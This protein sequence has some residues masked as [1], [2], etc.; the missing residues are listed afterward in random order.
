MV[1][2]R[3]VNLDEIP[4]R[5]GLGQE[6]LREATKL[7]IVHGQTTFADETTPS[8][9]CHDGVVFDKALEVKTLLTARNDS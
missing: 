9:V 3:P 6:R 8:I 4:F 1:A 2:S 7:Q 5:G